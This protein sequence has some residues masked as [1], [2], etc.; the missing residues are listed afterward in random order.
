MAQKPR[1]GK[2]PLGWVKDSREEGKQSK[3]STLSNPESKQS[4]SDKQ[5]SKP[6]KQDNQS[7]Q[8]LQET[9]TGNK[10]QAGLPEGWTRATFIMRAEHLE[11]LKALAYWDRKQIKE[12][13]DEA[14]EAYFKGKKVQP[15]SKKAKAV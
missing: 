5:E 6:D 10:S 3:S 15:V 7:K 11:K 13:V 2:D 14:L 4:K 8:E 1:I 12:V 9:A